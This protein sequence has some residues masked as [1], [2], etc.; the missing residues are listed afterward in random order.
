MGEW[1]RITAHVEGVAPGQ[2]IC[3]GARVGLQA[4]TG[5]TEAELLVHGLVP[6][7]EAAKGGEGVVVKAVGSPATKAVWTLR[8]TKGAGEVEASDEAYLEDD[9][10]Q[11]LAVVNGQVVAVKGKCEAAAFIVDVKPF[12]APPRVGFKGTLKDGFENVEWFGRGPHESYIDRYVSARVGAFQGTILDQTFKY[13]RPQENGNK[14]D[15]RWMSLKRENGSGLSLVAEEPSPTLGMQAHRYALSSFD[16]PDSKLAQ[17][18][19]HCGELEPRPE[20]DFCIDVLQM[21][22]GGIDSWGSKP[23]PEHMLKADQ[24]FEWCFS[25][26]PFDIQQTEEGGGQ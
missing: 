2:P 8:R 4:V 9:S 5:K 12:L 21:G 19:K 20:T 23:L 15:T 1:Q 25:L 16:G 11:F 6:T 13:V 26:R 22:V 24:K 3:D 14:L 7:T 10:G 17:A 18:I